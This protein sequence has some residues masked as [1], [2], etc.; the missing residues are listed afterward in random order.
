MD[1]FLL[2]NLI[3]IRHNTT[4]KKTSDQLDELILWQLQDYVNDE[5][6]ICARQES[7][8]WIIDYKNEIIKETMNQEK[9]GYISSFYCDTTTIFKFVSEIT[10]IYTKKEL[11]FQFDWWFQRLWLYSDYNIG[12]LNNIL[13]KIDIEM[14]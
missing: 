11:Q 12:R 10:S 3:C 5:N 7:L 8:C 4:D 1:T 14:I 13:N 2:V 9:M 6:N